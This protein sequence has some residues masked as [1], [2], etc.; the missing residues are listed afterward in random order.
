MARK[1]TKEI[2]DKYSRKLEGDIQRFDEN[3]KSE[4]ISKDYMNFKEEMMP[5]LSK[6]ER[7]C[8]S[9][10]NILKIKLAEKDRTKI[11]KQLDIA[12]LDVNPSQVMSFAVIVT[13]LSLII[14]SLIS[15]LVF[16]LSENFPILFFFLIIIATL[17]IFYYT[18]SLPGRLSNRYRLKV[19]S[20]MVP[21][22]L[23]IVIYMKHTSNL[24]RAVAF[25]A[26]QLKPP[27][28]LDLKKVFWDVE[29]SRFSNIKDSL[30]NYLDSWKDYSLEF[31]EAFHLIESSLYEPS[32]NRRVS[33]L[34]K[35]LQVILD[36]VYDKMLKYSHEVRAPL[37]N[38][39]MLGIVLPTLGLALIPLAST[40][41]GGALKWYHLFVV[42]NLLIPFFVFYLTNEIMLKRPGGYG[43][44]D[45]LELNPRYKEY[46]NKAP[47]IIAFLICFPLLLIGLSPFILQIP[48]VADTLGLNTDYAFSSIGVNF[49]GDSKLFEFIDLGGK[50]VGPFGLVA[51]LLSLL[52]P[53][54]FGLFFAMAYSMRTKELIKDRDS[55]KQ[56]EKE[57]TNSLF[58]LG[59]RLGDGT[60]AEL[61]IGKIAESTRGQKTSDFFN[62]INLNIHQAGM[63]LERAVFDKKRGAIIYYPSQLI[64]SSMRILVESVKKGLKVAARSLMS[65]SDYVKNIGKIT[66]RLKDLLAEV[67]SDMK[68]NMTFLAPLLAGIVV[69]LSAMITLILSKLRDMFTSQGDIELSGFGDLGT[70][71]TLFDITKM[72]P[73]YFLQIA[74][75]I[76]I[77]QVIFILTKTLV[78][79][80]AGED[81]LKE[82]YEI[83]RN[84][85]FGLLLYTIIAFIAILALSLLASIALGGMA[86]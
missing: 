25:A 70:I 45:L 40:L 10:G 41:L 19:S 32:E 21:C 46:K 43:E 34:E 54:S 8:Q 7:W 42:F 67:S 58:Q 78:T 47:Y 35:S 75:G 65:I 71:T 61:A 85:K 14:G 23:Y 20:Q 83:G 28:S 63:S 60:P 81:K 9:F 64:S 3:V 79:I 13:F 15:L 53:L 33:I 55:S 48:G 11:Q 4:S 36:G 1:S 18:Y 69:G 68:S 2:L 49:L 66:E 50:Q 30:D 73:P 37:T 27:I 16:F 5:S 77:I 62:L 22:I 17:F 52:V 24:E 6:Y 82:T 38:L 59:N 26:Q 31:V 80:N 39:Y 57:F 84:L 74:I 76:Y 56:L 44:T 72:I 51:L 86:S 29:T 12:H